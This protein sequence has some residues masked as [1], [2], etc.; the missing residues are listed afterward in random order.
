MKRLSIAVMLSALAVA[1]GAH[2]TEGG[3][4]VYPTGAEGYLCCAL[5][6]PGLYALIY[7]ERYHAGELRDNDGRNVAPPDFSITA[8]S[9]TPRIV[10]V[11]PYTFAG[12]SLAMHALLPLVTLD[13]HAG[14]Q[15][16]RRTGIGDMTFG[17]ALGWHVTPTLQT[18][19]AVDVFAPTGRYDKSDLANIGRHYWAIQPIAGISYGG[20]TGPVFDAKLMWTFNQRN[21]ATDYQSGQEFIV[22]YSAGWGF[23]NGLT[24]GAGG[25]VYR[26]MTDDSQ[27]GQTIAGN[28]G[29]SFAIGPSIKY[30]SGKGWFVTAK[31]QME[32]DV[33]NRPEGAAFWLKAVFPL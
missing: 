23:G 22:D 21:H 10:W 33:R 12:A 17:P 15:A 5:P 28:R 1:H 20:R 14:G 26:Q 27:A 29:R 11:T 13:V 24:V 7:A 9:V 25:Y 16:Q 19:L 4:S 32:T 31:Y 6:P 30:D 18:L 8:Y 3:G 2:A